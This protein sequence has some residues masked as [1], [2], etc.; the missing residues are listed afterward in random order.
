LVPEG[1]QAVG[2]TDFKFKIAPHKK[3]IHRNFFWQEDGYPDQQ[4]PVLHT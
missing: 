4:G 3:K 1:G 2:H